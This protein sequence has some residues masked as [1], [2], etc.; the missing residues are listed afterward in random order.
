MKGL[1]FLAGLV[2]LLYLISPLF[3]GGKIGLLWDATVI[4]VHISP[5]INAAVLYGQLELFY[6]FATIIVLIIGVFGGR[7]E[8]K[9]KGKK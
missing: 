2:M 6:A 8:S 9:G 7:N 5:S 1:V 3:G 4:T